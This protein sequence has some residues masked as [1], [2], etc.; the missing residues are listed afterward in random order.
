MQN[1]KHALVLTGIVLPGHA[2]EAVWPALASYFR[3]EPDSVSTKLV[4][5]APVTLK[6]SD[7][8]G[9]LQGLQDG[10]RSIGRPVFTDSGDCDEYVGIVMDVTERKAEEVAREELRRQLMAA[11]EDER[12][13]IAL[14]MHDHFGQQLSAI[15]LKLSELTR[16]AGRRATLGGELESLGRIAKQLDLD[17]EGRA[18]APRQAVARAVGERKPLRQR[19]AAQRDQGVDGGTPHQGLRGPGGNLGAEQAVSQVLH[20]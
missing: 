12:R 20:Q 11:Q 14:E 17:L 6:E 8:L 1:T 18:V 10:L 7:D 5:R 19:Y 4:P 3:M 9:K 16:D 13:R 15:V 2:A